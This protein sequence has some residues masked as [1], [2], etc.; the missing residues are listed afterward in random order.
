MSGFYLDPKNDHAFRRTFGDPKR[1]HVLRSLLNSV[2]RLRGDH[3]ITQLSIADPHQIPKLDGLK[4]TT[5]DVYC[6]DQRDHEFIVE[7]QISDKR[8][9]EHRALY[10]MSRSYADQLKRGESYINLRRVTLLAVL[11]FPFLRSPDYLATHLILD[12]VTL[13][14]RLKD[15][16]FAFLELPKFTKSK[17]QLETLVEK[18]TYFFKYAS[19]IP[20]R[21]IPPAL[22]VP[23]IEEA[24]EVLEEMGRDDL[25]KKLYQ[26]ADKDRMDRAAEIGKGYDDGR[27]KGLAEGEKKGREEEKLQIARNLLKSGM[28]L[29]QIAAAAGLSLSAVEQL[30]RR[31]S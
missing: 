8:D 14:H 24:F 28:D 30:S 17:A 31:K 12:A 20:L 29:K 13:E 4:E 23:E 16:A 25:Q 10:Y 15:F 18:W 22:R 7:M 19:Q 26:K 6:K 1:A 5:L 2:L 27:K 9:F 21:R 3:A 11:D